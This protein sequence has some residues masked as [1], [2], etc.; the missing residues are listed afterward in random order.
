MAASSSRQLAAL[1]PS[2]AMVVE[3][4]RFSLPRF[5]SKPGDAELLGHLRPLLARYSADPLVTK[6]GRVNAE[7]VWQDPWKIPGMPLEV[8]QEAERRRT[9]D[10]YFVTD[11]SVLKGGSGSAKSPATPHGF[12]KQRDLGWGIQ[13]ESNGGPGRFA[14]LKTTYDFC[15][16][17]T[18]Y[19]ERS[20]KG[21]GSSSSW[22]LDV[23]V[24]IDHKT[25]VIEDD[26]VMCHVFEWNSSQD[27]DPR[28]RCAHHHQSPKE[29]AEM[30]YS[31]EIH[32][33]RN[34]SLIERSPGHNSLNKPL[35]PPS[36]GRQPTCVSHHQS[37]KKNGHEAVHGQINEF[38]NL[39]DRTPLSPSAIEMLQNI[40]NNMEISDHETT[41]ETEKYKQL[42]EEVS[43]AVL[44]RPPGKRARTNKTKSDVWKS[45]TKLF[46]KAVMVL[47][48]CNHCCRVMTGDS[49]N[50]TSHLRR[51]KCSCCNHSN[52]A[53][54]AQPPVPHPHDWSNF[55]SGPRRAKKASA[56]TTWKT[57]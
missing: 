45:F 5:R 54:A 29:N 24:L 40:A 12:W 4:E 21:K 50:G 39:T 52:T 22:I 30:V 34:N 37:P 17:E 15:T 1:T 11:C 33:Q 41:M 19:E 42:D 8:Q 36:H 25:N 18:I 55:Q 9:R 23:Y 44:A 49:S 31:P 16:G 48:V 13:A 6:S 2:Q 51:H 26:L 38:S 32:G 56:N 7:L 43:S 57:G 35:S 3:D 10:K 20:S 46:T 47:A 14:G 53:T 27:Y 28:P